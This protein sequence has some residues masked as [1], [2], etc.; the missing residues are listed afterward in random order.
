MVGC[1][2]DRGKLA[3]SPTQPGWDVQAPDSKRIQV[4][5]LANP[6]DKWVNE[7]LIQTSSLMDSYALGI[8]EALLPQAVVIF[9]VDNLAAVGTSLG[10]RHGS[11]ETTLQFTQANFRR[12]L[13]DMDAFNA[14]GVRLYLAPNW[15]PQ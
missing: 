15:T 11:R 10:K 13:G 12:V 7:H 3:D 2:A 1:C 8:F 14:L 6:G 4:K 9:P 5:Y